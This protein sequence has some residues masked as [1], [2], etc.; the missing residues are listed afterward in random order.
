MH[1]EEHVDHILEGGV[2][3]RVRQFVLVL[4]VEDDTVLVDEGHDWQRPAR[5]PEKPRD[6]VEQPVVR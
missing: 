2:Y 3:I 4:V 1:L 5:A 6:G